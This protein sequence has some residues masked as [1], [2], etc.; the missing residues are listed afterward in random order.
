MILLYDRMAH[1]ETINLSFV[2]NE[3]IIMSRNEIL[4]Q[5]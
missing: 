4:E 2:L 1:V 3:F 5:I